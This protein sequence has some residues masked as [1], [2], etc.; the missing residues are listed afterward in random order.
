LRE[1]SIGIVASAVLYLYLGVTVLRGQPRK[2]T[3]WFLTG[4]SF[5]LALS[6][7]LVYFLYHAKTIAQG[8]LFFSLS[9]IGLVL[10]LTLQNFF[11]RSMT[12]KL[13][14]RYMLLII[15]PAAVPAAFIRSADSWVFPIVRGG[16]G[17][18]SIIGY[19]CIAFGS[20]IVFLL[21]WY[22]TAVLRRERE[23]AKLL[24]ISSVAVIIF[25]GIDIILHLT[26]N[27]SRLVSLIPFVFVP[28][29]VG[30][31][32]AIRKY[33][34][35]NITPEMVTRRIL[36]SIDEQVILVDPGGKEM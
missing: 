8:R 29:V 25:A 12:G 36:E 9:V 7:G 26:T 11:V 31:V 24:L 6:T 1:L 28:W 17:M 2:T 27:V 15:L 14:W 34:L 4:S 21:S 3:H 18:Y 16:P 30:Y 23:Q 33:Q 20:G 35:L 22:R 13:S 10:F 5:S 19:F 32:I